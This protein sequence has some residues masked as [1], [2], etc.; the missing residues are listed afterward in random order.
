M[1]AGPV[2]FTRALRVM[3]A[4]VKCMGLLVMWIVGMQGDAVDARC[5]LLAFISIR[6]NLRSMPQMVLGMCQKVCPSMV[7]HVQNHPSM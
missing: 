2:P 4:Q 7:L 6:E 1:Q 5:S 3:K